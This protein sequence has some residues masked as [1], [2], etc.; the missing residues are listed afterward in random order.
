MNMNIGKNY[1]LKLLKI[2]NPREKEIVELRRLKE[3][4]FKA[5]TIKS[6]I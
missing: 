2:L 6:K 1:S 3:K 5:K 4:T